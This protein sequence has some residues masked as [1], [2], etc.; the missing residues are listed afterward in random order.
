MIKAF[1]AEAAWAGLDPGAIH[2]MRTEYGRISSRDCAALSDPGSRP[3]AI[4]AGHEGIAATLYARLPGLGLRIGT[5]VSLISASPA[6][7]HGSLNP[8]LTHF[9]TDLDAAGV[10]IGEQL[11]IKLQGGASKRQGIR[12]T[13]IPMTF[14]AGESHKRAPSPLRV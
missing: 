3:T 8:L 7:D 10:M 4:L 9:K 13:L 12:S 1:Q 5:D 14:T 11:A 6:V 2:V